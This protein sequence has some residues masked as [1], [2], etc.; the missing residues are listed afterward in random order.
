MRKLKHLPL[1]Y[2]PAD[3]RETFSMAYALGDIFDE[4]RGPGSSPLSQPPLS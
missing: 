3:D 1:E 2:W 4:S